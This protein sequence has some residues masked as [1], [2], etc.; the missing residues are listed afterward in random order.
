MRK[1]R[2]IN[3]AL[4]LSINYYQGNFI[5]KRGFIVVSFSTVCTP[6]MVISDKNNNA[7]FE[8]INCFKL[9]NKLEN[10]LISVFKGF[11]KV[12]IT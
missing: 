9:F 11:I 1:L 10:F 4:V 5:N 8:I 12:V 6:C 2:V 3:T 7:V